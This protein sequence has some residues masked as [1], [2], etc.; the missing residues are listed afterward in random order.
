MIKES[1]FL[2]IINDDMIKELWFLNVINDQI[3][4]IIFKHH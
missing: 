2:N 1:W 3:K 4:V